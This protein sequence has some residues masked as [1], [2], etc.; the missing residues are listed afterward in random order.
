MSYVAAVQTE[1]LE[2]NKAKK[3]REHLRLRYRE[4]HAVFSLKKSYSMNTVLYFY[5]L[6][7]II[8]F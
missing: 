5:L 4:I 7:T 8:L 1:I 6:G 3:Q 2:M